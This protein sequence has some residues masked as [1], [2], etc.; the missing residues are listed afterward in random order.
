MAF[1]GLVILSFLMRPLLGSLSFLILCLLVGLGPIFLK[2][3]KR[4]IWKEPENEDPMPRRD[5]PSGGCI[6]SHEELSWD[7]YA[8]W[9]SVLKTEGYV[10]HYL[11]EFERKCGRQ[12]TNYEYEIHFWEELYGFFTAHEEI[13]DW[14]ELE[15]C[16]LLCRATF[17]AKVSDLKN[18]AESATFKAEIAEQK[19]LAELEY[20]DKKGKK[21]GDLQWALWRRKHDNKST[22]EY[23]D[24]LLESF[25]SLALK[26][27]A[28]DLSDREYLDSLIELHARAEAEITA[29]LDHEEWGPMQDR[30]IDT[31]PE[32]ATVKYLR[33]KE[34][35]TN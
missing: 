6:P 20:E 13:E 35:D 27:E 22:A 8:A 33:I 10:E 15:G 28:D 1:T 11:K 25:K 9:L 18:L 26:R 29:Y 7:R 23:M 5:F 14:P 3:I 31:V 19:N 17:K 2:W 16:E 32:K 4:K 12:P 30:I 24:D 21:G 34:D